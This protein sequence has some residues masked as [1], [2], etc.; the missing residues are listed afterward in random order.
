MMT[1]FFFYPK[2]LIILV[3]LYINLAKIYKNKMVKMVKWNYFM[4]ING[5]W[6]SDKRGFETLSRS[7]R[8]I[9]WDQLFKKKPKRCNPRSRRVV[10]SC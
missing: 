10:N 7:Q 9:K 8:R 2:I 1:I 4:T 5:Y 6:S 3:K